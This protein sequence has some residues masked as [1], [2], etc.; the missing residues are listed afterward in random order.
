VSTGCEPAKA[1]DPGGDFEDLAFT[2][3]NAGSDRSK[4]NNVEDPNLF[5]AVDLEP[6]EADNDFDIGMYAPAAIAGAVWEDLNG[7]G[8]CDE[9]AVLHDTNGTVFV[10]VNLFDAELNQLGGTTTDLVGGYEFT[11]LAPG[12]TLC[13]L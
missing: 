1:G 10:T 5:F 8:I 11:G 9:N 12:T 3:L 6:G 2:V 7:N 4:D 13:N